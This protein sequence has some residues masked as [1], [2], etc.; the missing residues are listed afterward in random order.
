[1]QMDSSLAPTYQTKCSNE[2]YYVPPSSNK[3]QLAPAESEN[4]HPLTSP[5]SNP[6]SNMANQTGLATPLI[7]TQHGNVI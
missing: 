3:H 6:T 7:P 4:N 1:M 5:C 2:W